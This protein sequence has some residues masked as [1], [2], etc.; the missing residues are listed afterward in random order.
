MIRLK[1]TPIHTQE[2]T[3]EI[4]QISKNGL[5]TAPMKQ[6]IKFNHFPTP[7]LILLSAAF[8][9]AFEPLELF[10]ASPAIA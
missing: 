10:L 6:G 7:P 3:T 4:K 9:T 1:M 2:V 8:V 5:Q